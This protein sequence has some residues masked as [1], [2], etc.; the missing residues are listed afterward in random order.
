MNKR[1]ALALLGFAALFAFLSCGGGGGGGS[2]SRMVIEES[3]NGF[4]KLL[5]HRVYAADELG[6]PTDR[7]VEITRI[8][9]IVNN[10]TLTNPILPPVE[11]PATTV[12]PNGEAGNHFFYT[13]F[14]QDIGVAS[15]MDAAAGAAVNFNLTGTITVLGVDPL[16]GTV[17]PVPGRAF[18]GGWTYGKVDSANPSQLLW[19]QW[20]GKNGAALVVAGYEDLYLGTDHEGMPGWGFPG[21]QGNKFS[22]AEVLVDDGTFVFIPDAD[23]N[24]ST[25]ETFPAGLQVR[26]K[27]TE[28]VLAANGNRLLD[29]GL[30]SSTVGPDTI[31]P[32]V[33]VS[34]QSQAPTI[35]PGNGD[36]DVDPQTTISVEFT[37]PLQ[38]L[39]IGQLYTGAPPALSAAILVEFGP[40]NARVQVPFSVLP[41]SVYDLSRLE[42]IPIYNFPGSGPTGGGLTC[43]TFS[44]ISVSVNPAQFQDLRANVNTLSPSTYFETA[45]GPGLVNAPV[46]PDTIYVA[47]GGTNPGVSVIDLNGFGQGCGD[48]TYDIAHPIVEGNTNF[49]NNPNVAIQGALLIPPLSPGVCTFDGGSPGVFTLVRDSSLR[50]MV[51]GAPILSSVGDMALGHAMDN[52]FNNSLPFGCQAGGGNICAQTGLKI[53]A[54]AAGGANTLAPATVSTFPIKTVFGAENLVS[55]VPHPNPPP[56]TFPPLCLSPLIGAVEPTS[57]VMVQSIPPIQNLLVPGSFPL[58]RPELEIPPTGLLTLEQNGFFEGPS[59]PQSNPVN[60]LTYMVRQQ[61]GQFM[62][63]I[64]RSANAVVVFNSNRFTVIDRIS[65]PDPTSLA[66]SP[67]LEYLAVTNQTADLV[68]IIDTD[69]TSS[70]FH[71]VVKNI[72]VGRGPIGIAWEEG[73]EDI[74]VCNQA[75]STASL[76][77]AFTLTVRKT[78]SNQLQQ[79]FEVATTP[80]QLGFGFLKIVYYAYFLNGDGSVAVFESG[81]DGVNG[82]GYDDVIGQVPFTFNR[83][84]TIQTDVVNLNSAVWIVHED[85]LDLATGDPT[86]QQGGALSN[87]AITG[88]TVG[89]IYLDPGFFSNP[90]MRDL[91]F[92]VVA[93]IGEG[94]DGLTGVP[95]DIAVDCQRNLTA[96]TNHSTLF[97][98]G[99]PLS[100][101]GKSLVKATAGGF[102]PV[103]APQFLFLAVPSSVE[104]PGVVDVIEF[105][106]GLRRYDTN[107]FHDGV[108]SI[109]V[110]NAFGLMD[111]IRQ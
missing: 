53:V 14:R 108:Q 11:W 94:P 28:G 52:S 87:M 18:I 73:N 67:N 56:L 98:A 88:A 6:L 47:R 110:P 65:L 4:G 59:P 22:G 31:S 37:E 42:L 30:A 70:S 99:F 10:V 86:G 62:Y 57:T 61:I 25:H 90:N 55:W 97:S 75:D 33:A 111:F 92:S 40:S 12:L 101:N 79:P 32:E 103:A 9:D 35:I 2:S 19:E 76:I 21:T 26:M 49:P 93:S 36:I 104:G 48:P 17:T 24:L 43:G 63:V 54:I 107:A 77:S 60:C 68:S 51:A 71:R 96:L 16:T 45:E 34:G 81:P 3:S 7:I 69:P 50:D 66:M 78:V 83:P 80:R 105:A 106:S 85:P 41:L 13:K 39:S 64:D 95:L 82:W 20:V 74:I 89:A 15:V 84:K 1:L 109:P 8:A 23:R 100:V 46:A 72:P 58:G 5:P 38:I 44:Q 102:A 29:E 91:E 27:M